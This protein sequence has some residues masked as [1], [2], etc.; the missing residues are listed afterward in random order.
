ME[1]LERLDGWTPNE[2][3]HMFLLHSGKP[4]I[5]G[6]V[7][8]IDRLHRKGMLSDN[9]VTPYGLAYLMKLGFVNA[10][11]NTDILAEKYRDL[12]PAKIVSG[13][14]PVK[15]N[16]TDIKTKL[17]LFRKKYDYSD[18]EIL[19]AAKNYVDQMSRNNYQYMTLAHYLIMKDGTSK[20]ADFCD[21]LRRKPVA[22]EQ[23]RWGNTV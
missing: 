11:D 3:V 8:N 2:A 6:G 19:E 16:L 12:F 10:A 18:E 1:F 14:Y 4:S 15:S 20:L 22:D 13:G 9:V 21:E 17:K 23:E 5:Y 7:S